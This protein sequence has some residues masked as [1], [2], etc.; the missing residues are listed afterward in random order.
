LV[1]SKGGTRLRTTAQNARSDSK[2]E[3]GAYEIPNDNEWVSDTLSLSVFKGQARVMLK[4]ETVNGFGN[5][6]FLDDVEVRE[7]ATVSRPTDSAPTEISI[8]PNPTTSL[9]YVVLNTE[10]ALQLRLTVLDITGRVVIP[11][12]VHDLGVGNHRLAVDMSDLPAGMY[13]LRA[14]GAHQTFTTFRV[15]K[16]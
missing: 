11:A 3:G 5:N 8:A 10:A 15:V 9:T 16:R 4:F 7:L 6:L 1:Y 14:E 12:T 2:G 13:A